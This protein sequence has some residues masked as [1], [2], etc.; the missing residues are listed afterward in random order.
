MHLL[1]KRKGVLQ[2][3]KFSRVLCVI[4]SAAML[5]GAFCLQSFAADAD[6]FNTNDAVRLY[7]D[8]D[9]DGVIEQS[10]FEYILG[11]LSG[12][13]EMPAI[14][15]PEY[16]AADIM[17]DGI[18]MEDARRCYRYLM[19]YDTVMTY[20]PDEREVQLFND[21]VN[22]I[23]SDDFDDTVIYY[24]YEYEF[25]ET[26][27][28]DF[29]AFTSIIEGAMAEEDTTTEKYYRLRKN[30][31]IYSI[32]RNGATESNYPGITRD[33][34]S[35]LKPENLQDFNIEIGVPCT[36][37]AD[38]GAPASYVS[39]STTYDIAHLTAQEAQYTDCIKVTIELK[40]ESYNKDI[41]QNIKD[42]AKK[43]LKDGY[44][45]GETY[46]LDLYQTGLYNLYG[47]DIIE[48]GAQYP[49]DQTTGEEGMETRLIAELKD[50]QTGGTA[51][52]YFDRATLNPI[53]ASYTTQ[54][55][56]DQ[57]VRMEMSFS[58]FE[59]NGSME[60]RNLMIT[61][62]N[63]WFSDYFDYK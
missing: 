22:I 9:G 32:S 60:P 13:I 18:T 23:K 1:Y 12:K 29:G 26:K 19:G 24:I 4:L 61:Q 10:D 57:T 48:L 58:G 54:T 37:S 40:N 42:L 43:Q 38:V 51:V 62:H 52:Y 46:Y 27:N 55:D 53:A 14:G 3:K 39:G 35:T 56:I 6:R 50:I 63:Y 2:M 17:G 36:F 8:I 7:G 41:P 25:M 59:L 31:Y 11:I 44:E 45:E 49:L 33:I 5:L 28:M 16:Y 20:S 21:M 30:E 47:T 34:V 15:S